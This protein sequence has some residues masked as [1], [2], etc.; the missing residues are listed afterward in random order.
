L[1]SKIKIQVPE[2]PRTVFSYSLT[3]GV[4]TCCGELGVSA[5]L[6][7][8][9]NPSKRTR[10][11]I[12]YAKE[13]AHQTQLKEGA[14]LLTCRRTDTFLRLFA[15]SI[16]RLQSLAPRTASSYAFARPTFRRLER[17]SL[18]AVR[19]QKRRENGNRTCFY[20]PVAP[21]TM[22]LARGLTVGYKGRGELDGGRNSKC[23]YGNA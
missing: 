21:R 20:E 14:E 9:L 1:R 10:H 4:F 5:T 12:R 16:C 2:R 15:P 17:K 22:P 18:E 23:H 13:H 11:T 8:K 3:N 19:R 6:S 7:T